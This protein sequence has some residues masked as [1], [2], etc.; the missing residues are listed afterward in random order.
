M[1]LIEADGKQLLARR[2]LAVPRGR[3]YGPDETVEAVAGGAAI[4]AQL[5]AGARGK[6]GLGAARE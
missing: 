1:R 2:G 5:L 4:K 3:L 6:N